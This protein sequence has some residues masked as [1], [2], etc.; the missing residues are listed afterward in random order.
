MKVN[1]NR[2]GVITISAEEIVRFPEGLLGFRDYKRYVLMEPGE[3]A[4]FKWLQSVDEGLLAFVVIEPLFL[5]DEYDIEISGECASELKLV[6]PSDA[7]I[8]A[9]VTIAEAPKKA[10]AN[11]QAPIIM[12]SECRIA[13]QVILIDSSY[14]IRHPIMESNESLQ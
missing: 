7:N 5:I 4:P 14:N 10:T 2:F 13:K 3:I 8:Y 12:N 9:I 11:L 1:T 6:S